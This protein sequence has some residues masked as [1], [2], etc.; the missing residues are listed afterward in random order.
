MKTITI[1]KKLVDKLINL[2]TNYPGEIGGVLDINKKGNVYIKKIIC[3]KY[4][5]LKKG[6]SFAIAEE[7]DKYT[8]NN[9]GFIAFHTH[10]YKIMT[11]KEKKEKT[12]QI[13]SGDDLLQSLVLDEQYMWS[14]VI[15]YSG[16]FIYKGRKN[17]IGQKYKKCYGELNKLSSQKQREVITDIVY[18]LNY[19]YVYEYQRGNISLS[20]F[21]ARIRD[22][23][24]Y[25]IYYYEKN[26]KIKIP[27]LDKNKSYI[28]KNIA[29]KLF[30]IEVNGLNKNGFNEIA[31]EFGYLD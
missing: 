23:E 9:T 21:I 27:I 1:S 8:Y 10:P 6:V 15:D 5:K 16:I 13:P 31:K 24:G 7:I 28:P 17:I 19:L 14:M 25:E 2:A 22:Y 11:K 18:N 29:K 4:E 3:P 30:N 26:E 20:S 12:I